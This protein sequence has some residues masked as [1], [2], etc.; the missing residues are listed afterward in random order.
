MPN[1]PAKDSLNPY[2]SPAA[3]VEETPELAA[4]VPTAR[5]PRFC[6]RVFDF[7]MIICL[8]RGAV[9]IPMLVIGA[10]DPRSSVMQLL[11]LAIGL[12]GLTA[13]LLGFY[14]CVKML[15]RQLEGFSL[16]RLAVWLW[17]GLL[18]LELVVT[19]PTMLGDVAKRAS[20]L[21]AAGWFG[22]QAGMLWLFL[23]GLRRFYQ[24]QAG[25]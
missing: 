18:V 5:L 25:G 2:A 16:G 7:F 23:M 8:V 21:A 22:T 13:G 3:V 17:A 1:T 19:G 11:V 6:R 10:A 24:W 12:L 4:R 20:Q 15:N 9:S 14:S